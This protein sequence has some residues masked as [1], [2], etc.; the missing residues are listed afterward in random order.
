MTDAL[1]PTVAASPLLETKLYVPR[2]RSGLVSRPIL[3]ERLD[4]ALQRKL[5]L[6]CAPAGFG[7]TTLLAEWIAATPVSERS[8]AWVSLD[9][10]DNDPTLFWG[11][12]ISA[13]Q[14]LPFGVGG[15]S[16]S[17][18]QSAQPPPIEALLGTLINEVASISHDFVV[19]LD[20]YHLIDTQPVH[21]GTAFLLEHMPPQMHLVIAGRSDP[22]LPL[23]RL[24]GGGELAELRA[25]DLRFSADEATAFLNQVMGLK[26]SVQEVAALEARTEGWIAGLQLAALSMQGRDDIAGFIRAFTGDDRY[27]VDY[28][29]EEVLQRQP[30]PVR[31][32]LLQTSVLD[33]LS[34]P[35][36]DAVTGEEGG[37]GILDALERGNVF[38]IP[39]DDKRSWYRYHHLFADVLSAHSMAELPDQLPIRHVRASEWYEDNGLPGD[40][41]RHALAAKDWARA[42]GIIEMEGPRMLRSRQVAT[43]LRWLNALPDEVIRSRPVLSG[44]YA[45]ASLLS[46]Q[47]DAVEPRLRDAERWLDPTS[48]SSSEMAVVNQEWFRSLP[49]SIA[50]ARAFQA[51]ARGDLPAIL[52]YARS[53]LDLLPEDNHGLRSIASAVVAV[54]FWKSGDL[55]AAGRACAQAL[56]D[57]RMSGDTTSEIA[58]SNVYA[59]VTVAQ[60]RL[61]EAMNTY[62]H[63]LRLATRQEGLVLRGTA[64]SHVGMSEIR[65]EHN[66]LEAATQHLLTSQE[67]GEQATLLETKHRWCV[68]MA[69]VKKA[70]G[71]LAGALGMLDEAEDLYSAVPILGVRPVAA[72]KVQLWIA[73]GRLTEAVGWARQRAQSGDGNQGYLHEY[74][75]ITVARV[76]VAQYRSDRTGDSFDKAVRL[77]DRLLKAAEEEDRTGSVIEILVQQALAHEAKG[78]TARALVPLERALVLAEPEGFV[79][80]FVDEGEPMHDLLRRVPAGRASAYIVLLLLAFDNPE[81]GASN[82]VQAAAT[83][84]AEPLTTRELEVL[85]LIAAGMRNQEI[86]DHLFISVS[87]VKRHIANAYGK[88]GVGHRT[89]AVARAA[90]MNLL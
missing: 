84:L 44:G 64:A 5:T 67:L 53:A 9:E 58:I 19:V 18:L 4:Q 11:Y 26:L 86:A 45:W 68:A 71:D 62:E 16:L 12:F 83:D 89:E 2:W 32:F 52:K 7:K 14:T 24:R 33:R 76:L 38:L 46:G 28:L 70:Q 49:G 21:H 59:Q 30:E 48:A 20:D 65:L 55:E 77:L 50:T 63:S 56:A 29:M 73:Q 81:Q 40:A 36:C 22:P 75:S 79:R 1:R 87:T 34:G 13:L 42:A 80:I 6:V 61:H 23:S 47:F 3:I 10:G 88:L 74:E 17:L 66:D 41:V 25:S 35:L 27:I 90:D 57:V 39:L 43:F 31:R 15:K 82:P 37:K 72:M 69:R 78:E 60:G 54:A 8:V 51:Q 85:R